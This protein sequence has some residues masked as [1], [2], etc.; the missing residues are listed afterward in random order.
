[1]FNVQRLVGWFW[2]IEK[3]RVPL[4]NKTKL[5]ISNY[6]Y[7]QCKKGKNKETQHDKRRTTPLCLALGWS[8]VPVPSCLFPGIWS[9]Q[10]Q[11]NLSYKNVWNRYSEMEWHSTKNIRLFAKTND[12]SSYYYYYVCVYVVLPNTSYSNRMA[13]RLIAGPCTLG[14]A[15]VCNLV[16]C[17]C[18]TQK[19]SKQKWHEIKQNKKKQWHAGPVDGCFFQAFTSFEAK[20]SKEVLS[21]FIRRKL[22]RSQTFLVKLCLTSWNMLEP[23]QRNLG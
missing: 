5:I 18:H 15:D 22:S 14:L 8:V 23:T 13:G 3:R 1:M 17:C 20:R 2:A 16:D 9:S 4:L 19:K 6:H 7:Q 11:E 12:S 21:K 10:E